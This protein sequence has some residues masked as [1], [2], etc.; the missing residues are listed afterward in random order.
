M[1][2]VPAETTSLMFFI[3]IL[4]VV[5]FMQLGGIYIAQRRLG[6]DAQKRTLLFGIAYLLVLSAFSVVVLSG[7]LES[8][9]FP[10]LMI[11]LGLLNLGAIYF[12]LSTAGGTI[13]RG[14]TMSELVAFQFFRVP[15][16]LVLHSWAQQGTI[17]QTMTWTGQNFDII[18]GIVVLLAAPFAN[19]SRLIAWGANIV[20][21]A[22]LLNV[23]RVAVMSS[24]LP[25]AWGVEPPLQ[26][27]FHLP[28]AFIIPVCVSGALTWHLLLT[29]KLL[30]HSMK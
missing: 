7:I 1:T 19:R 17:P 22:L 24:P 30:T 23:M 5:V 21:F 16:E 20:G 4:S 2:F 29:R 3:V 25:F 26:L 12:A 11:T 14:L 27:G 15:L 6:K 18:T 10:W 9:P 13:A 8:S 28:Y